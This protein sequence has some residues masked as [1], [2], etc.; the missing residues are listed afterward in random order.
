MVK[1]TDSALRSI[2]EF[3]RNK[4]SLFFFH[5]ESNLE[6]GDVGAPAVERHRQVAMLWQICLI[7]KLNIA[8]P[9]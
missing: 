6:T 4:V 9:V 8:S 2:E 7:A 3:I 5:L 1:L